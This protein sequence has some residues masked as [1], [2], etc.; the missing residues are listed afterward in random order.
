MTKTSV[1]LYIDRIF[2]CQQESYDHRFGEIV[3]ELTSDI[4]SLENSKAFRSMRFVGMFLIHIA[5]D[6]DF[7][8]WPQRAPSVFVCSSTDPKVFSFSRQDTQFKDSPL[9]DVDI[10]LVLCNSAVGGVARHNYVTV[11][12]NL[13]HTATIVGETSKTDHQNNSN[14]F[15]IHQ[16]LQAKKLPYTVEYKGMKN[17]EDTFAC[18]SH[19]AGYI[20]FILSNLGLGFSM[21]YIVSFIDQRWQ[22]TVLN[23]I[24]A[25]YK[26]MRECLRFMFGDSILK[27][28]DITQF[29]IRK[30]VRIANK[31]QKKKTAAKDTIENEIHNNTVLVNLADNDT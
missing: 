27:K 25:L 9:L 4:L 31:V 22:N 15:N 14:H 16:M 12:N 30:S 26:D 3:V 8:H 29:P 28:H 2:L 18:L 19:A 10:G 1:I 11:M 6:I 20:Y 13:K 21:P 24:L 7:N 17:Q 23:D 5:R